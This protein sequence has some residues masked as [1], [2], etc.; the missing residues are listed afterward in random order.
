MIE[1]IYDERY[2]DRDIERFCRYSDNFVF[3]KQDGYLL[4]NIDMQPHQFD[5]YDDTMHNANITIENDRLIR[6]CC[7]NYQLYKPR[8]NNPVCNNEK[9]WQYLDEQT[10]NAR[11]YTQITVKDLQKQCNVS[12]R[13]SHNKVIGRMLFELNDTIREVYKR[14]DKLP[15]GFASTCI[16]YE[17][18]YCMAKFI[19]FVLP[20]FVFSRIFYFVFPIIS[21]I[22]EFDYFL[23]NNGHDNAINDI[24]LFQV[25]LFGCYYCLVVVWIVNFLNVS[26]FYYWTKLI[27]I[28]SGEWDLDRKSSSF[29]E[30]VLWKETIEQY[31]KMIDDVAVQ[32]ILRQYLGNDIASIVFEYYVQI[33]ISQ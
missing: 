26:S 33:S 9:L 10:R 17:D 22:Q 15:G 30:T 5:P 23:N 24:V 29:L 2:D 1:Y 16:N 8:T 27:G 11:L 21:L 6:I 13:S 19:W 31:N 4:E 25:V 28:G 18:V 7:L 32:E 14:F 20:L 12:R 3:N